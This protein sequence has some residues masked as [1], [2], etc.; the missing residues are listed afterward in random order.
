MLFLNKPLVLTGKILMLEI[1]VQFIIFLLFSNINLTN[2]ACRPL[3]FL[4]IQDYEK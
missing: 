3:L 2:V 1:P 4:R